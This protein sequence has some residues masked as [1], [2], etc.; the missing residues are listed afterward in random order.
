MAAGVPDAIG[1]LVEEGLYACSDSRDAAKAPALPRAALVAIVDR[2]WI[3]GCA[4][5]SPLLEQRSPVRRRRR[6][7]AGDQYQSRRVR[8]SFLL[9]TSLP[10]RQWAVAMSR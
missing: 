2:T 6:Y 1:A 9:T 10:V 5:A 3:S 7:G 4:L 8:F